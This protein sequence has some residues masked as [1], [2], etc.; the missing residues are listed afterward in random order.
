M[1]WHWNLVGRGTSKLVSEA[2]VVGVV[3]VMVDVVVAG[4]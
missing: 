4:C 1:E 2:V 3:V